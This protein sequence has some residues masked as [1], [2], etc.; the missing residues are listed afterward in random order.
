M[1]QQLG[2]ASHLL[3]LQ[4]RFCP[5]K[6]IKKVAKSRKNTLRSPFG[7]VY[8]K[9]SVNL[10]SYWVNFT[11]TLTLQMANFTVFVSKNRNHP[12][13]HSRGTPHH[14]SEHLAG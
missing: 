4:A 3:R 13:E 14:L 12:S 9:F 11:V 10:C 8:G 1:S 6:H 2:A 7:R 5:Q